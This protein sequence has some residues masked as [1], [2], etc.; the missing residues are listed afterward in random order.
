MRTVGNYLF[1]ICF[2]TADAHGRYTLTGLPPGV[3]TLIVDPPAKTPYVRGETKVNASTP[4][5]GVATHDIEL[6]RLPVAQGRVT[7][8]AT[9]KPV[10][11]WVEYRPLATNASLAANPIFAQPGNLFRGP[12]A[13]LDATGRYSIPVLPGGG[14]LLV[15][16]EGNYASAVF[17]PA[18]RKT[19]VVHDQDGELLDTRPVA[20]WPAQVDAYRRID[21]VQGRDV[22]ADFAVVPAGR[23][24]LVLVFPGDTA[25][26][27]NVLGLA[28][29]PRDSRVAYVAGKT[30]VSRLTPG[31]TRRVYAS[32]HDG[33]LAG[34]ADV[35]GN[36]TGAATLA[37]RPTATVTGRVLDANGQPLAGVGLRPAFDD[38]LIVQ[39]GY[40]ARRLTAAE[41]RRDRLVNGYSDKRGDGPVATTDDRGAFRLERVVAGSAIRV[42]RRTVHAARR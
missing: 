1:P 41:E 34:F 32:T 13:T 10:A 36:E 15:T 4:G 11:G 19:G 39:G 17:D 42:D 21:A 20:A 6:A 9:G 5:I 26:D 23:R 2:T 40:M 12:T 3:H 37:L 22:A 28:P 24:P 8:A 25:K 30:V 18:D 16:A 35:S 7:D 31:E 29:R 33:S 38:G 14:V 27:A